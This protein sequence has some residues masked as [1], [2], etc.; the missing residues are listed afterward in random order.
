MALRGTT[1]E[2]QAKRLKALVYGESGVGK[3]T[4]AIQFPKPYLID[5]E[6]GSVNDQYVDAIAERDGAVFQTTSFDEIVKEVRL[7]I[8]E[9]HDFRTLVIDPITVVYEDMLNH[10]ERRVGSDFGKHYSAAKKEWKRLTA[11]LSK[12]DMNVILTAHSKVQYADDGS[13]KVAGVTYDGAKGT[14]YWVDLA[15]EC[16]RE[17]GERKARV[18]KTRIQTLAEGEEVPLDFEHLA[19]LYGGNL[20]GQAQA[21]VLATSE[22][23]KELNRMVDLHPEGQVFLTKWLRA[24]KVEEI[25]DMTHEQVEGCIK[26]NGW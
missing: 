4:F 22:E 24:A 11:L 8:S 2:K 26:W 7:L 20:D 12:L 15:L 1:P 13:F 6:R 3:T 14:D 17:E 21:V 18:V 5:T 9:K 19:F 10:W 25:A 16:F 23:V